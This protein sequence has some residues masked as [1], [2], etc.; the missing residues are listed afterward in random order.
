VCRSIFTHHFF[1]E[2]YGTQYGSFC[3]AGSSFEARFNFACQKSAVPLAREAGAVKAYLTS[4][5]AGDDNEIFPYGV[6]P[7]FLRSST[8]LYRPEFQGRE[9]WFYN[10]SDPA[11]VPPATNVPYGFFHRPLKVSAVAE[12]VLGLCFEVG[13]A[14]NHPK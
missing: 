8:A 6:D 11:Q 14:E 10:T 1:F 4:L 9:L 2:T 7:A 5:F 3:C 12:F 13:F